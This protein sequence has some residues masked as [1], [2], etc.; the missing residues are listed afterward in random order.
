MDDLP[1]H[2]PG[3]LEHFLDPVTSGANHQ[4]TFIMPKRKRDWAGPPEEDGGAEKGKSPRM[5]RVE[6]KL[7]QGHKLLNR[8]FK[9]AKGFER[10]KLSRRRKTACDKSDA[11]D[12]VRIDEEIEA[13]KVCPDRSQRVRIS[14]ANG[15]AIKSGA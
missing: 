10:Q 9:T 3:L 7:D 6:Y 2:V 1:W 14:F 13:I 5:R 15:S 11:K 8:A 4:I 12:V